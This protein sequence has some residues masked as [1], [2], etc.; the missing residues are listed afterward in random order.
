MNTQSFQ[1]QNTEKGDLPFI[2]WLFD[3]AIAYQKRKN[4][5]VWPDY[6][7]DLLKREIEE[8]LQFK[9]VQTGT[10]ACIFSICYSDKIVWRE[11]DKDDSIFLHRI[12]VN[13]NFKGQKQFE[14]ILNYAKKHILE[15]GIQFIRMDTWADNPT[16][17]QYY[18]SFEFEIVD[19][20]T[21]PDTED[22]PIQQRGNRIVL[23]EYS[24]K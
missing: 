10:I 11:R 5:P 7:K 8:K 3:E 6:D 17:I 9:I 16:L 23:L 18:Q 21:T 15:K 1:I 24:P 2:H 13:P 22:L 20:F 14:K 4:V 19:Y 12:V